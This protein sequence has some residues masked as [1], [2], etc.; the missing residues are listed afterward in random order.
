MDKIVNFCTKGGGI[1]RKVAV[2]SF[3]M[4]FIGVSV[5]LAQQ[6]SM[7]ER[8]FARWMAGER[9][10]DIL[11]EDQIRKWDEIRIKF[12]KER[13]ELRARLRNARLDLQQ[14]LKNQRVPNEKEVYK[15]LS[16]IT[17]L[18]EQLR[19]NQLAQQIE[20]RKLLTDEQWQEIQKMK[21]QA[22]KGL[23][24]MRHR[25]RGTMGRQS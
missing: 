23:M 2:F 12:Q 20:F 3:M 9:I 19:K 8:L 21:F 24:R 5:A 4:I 18:T 1:M 14:L 16:E 25:P 6:G 17:R 13:N 11:N 15:K 22:K 7:R 10:Q